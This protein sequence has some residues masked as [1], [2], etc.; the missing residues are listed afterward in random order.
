MPQLAAGRIVERRD[1]ARLSPIRPNKR[2]LQTVE[3][4]GI[5]EFGRRRGQFIEHAA[6]GGHLLKA[7]NLLAV[8]QLEPLREQ[9]LGQLLNPRV[10]LLGFLE[11]I[12]DLTAIPAQ[13]D[14]LVGDEMFA[15]PTELLVSS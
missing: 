6:R 14:K 3:C 1:Q 2:T 9:C 11:T 13:D 4:L 7:A 5:L 8:S 15:E 12:A 10:V